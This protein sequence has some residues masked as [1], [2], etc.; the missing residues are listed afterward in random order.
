MD[1]V[2]INEIMHTTLKCKARWAEVEPRGVTL[3]CI[4]RREFQWR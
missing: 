3:L 4:K 2:N 1:I